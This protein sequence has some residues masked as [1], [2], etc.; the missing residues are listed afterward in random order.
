M[1]YYNHPRRTKRLTFKAE[2]AAASIENCFSKTSN[3]K[4]DNDQKSFHFISKKRVTSD[5]NERPVIQ[6]WPKIQSS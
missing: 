1:H 6:L 4:Y 2:K 5:M 3:I